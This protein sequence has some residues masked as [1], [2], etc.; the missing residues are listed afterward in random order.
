MTFIFYAVCNLAGLVFYYTSV[1]ETRGVA[2]GRDM[3]KVFG[4]DAK[5]EEFGQGEVEEVEDV[6]EIDEITPLLVA[7]HR[8][9]RRSSVAIVV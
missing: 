3:A 2:L 7:D 6:D 8:R 9:R 5:D 1:P 4:V